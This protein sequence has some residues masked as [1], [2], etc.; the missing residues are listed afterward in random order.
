MKHGSEEDASASVD[1]QRDVEAEA[2]LTAAMV[3]ALTAEDAMPS[4]LAARVIAKGEVIV[5]A[6]AAPVERVDVPVRRPGHARDEV[7]DLAR[8]RSWGGW[9]VAAA[10]GIAMLV[11]SR[12]P[13]PTTRTLAA[14]ELRAEVLQRDSVAVRLAWTATNDVAARGATGDVVW[15]DAA[16]R[17]V[18][19]FAG[20]EAN[21]PTRWQYQLWI[22]DRDRN[23]KYPVDGGVFNVPA[24]GGDV[25]VPIAARLRVGR[26]V[27]FAVTVEQPGGVVVSSRERIVVLAQRKS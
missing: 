21:D 3:R 7:V 10:A 18:M 13:A 19:R 27:M 25:L 2:E 6:A 8:Y 5:R 12:T 9:M 4:A 15:S 20:L 23:E 1:R 14:G 11:S 16:Q 17:G 24:G 22:F 26:A